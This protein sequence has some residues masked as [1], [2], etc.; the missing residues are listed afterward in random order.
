MKYLKCFLI[1]I[2]ILLLI[3]FAY[4]ASIWI[5]FEISDRTFGKIDYQEVDSICLYLSQNEIPC[6][7]RSFI[8]TSQ[9]HMDFYLKK[10]RIECGRF[11]IEGDSC[12]Y[13]LDYNQYDYI[14]SEG[15]SLHSLTNLWYD[16]YSRFPSYKGTYPLSNGTYDEELSYKV[17]VYRVAPKGRYRENSYP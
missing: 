14:L 11:P 13:S 3:P 15:K 1:I 5:F 7:R 4:I 16:D 2:A 10:Y 12:L 8:I 6:G 9:E 17:Y